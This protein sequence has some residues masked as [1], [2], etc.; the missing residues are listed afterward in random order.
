MVAVAHRHHVRRNVR[1]ARRARGDCDR[2]LCD[3]VYRLLNVDRCFRGSIAYRAGAHCIAAGLRRNGNVV[4]NHAFVR[5]HQG[6]C[7]NS[8]AENDDHNDRCN[9]FHGRRNRGRLLPEAETSGPGQSVLP[10]EDE[11]K[12]SLLS[13]RNNLSDP[14]NV[15]VQIIGYRGTCKVVAGDNAATEI[16]VA[17]SSRCAAWVAAAVRGR[18]RVVARAAG[19][20]VTTRRS[21]GRHRICERCIIGVRNRRAVRIGIRDIIGE[22]IRSGVA[23]GVQAEKASYSSCVIRGVGRE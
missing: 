16:A 14:R 9:A 22:R 2:W 17:I 7:A 1:T 5:V 20:G 13:C 12:R 15:E 8:C 21:I 23:C 4:R 19:R 11:R 18:E 6:R 10:G 3:A